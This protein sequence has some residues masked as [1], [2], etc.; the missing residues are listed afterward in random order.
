M[1]QLKYSVLILLT[2]IST[3]VMLAL[4]A[5]SQPV[6]TKKLH[7]SRDG[8]IWHIVGGIGGRAGGE[9]IEEV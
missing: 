3:V 4:Y 5:S 1:I 8:H 6:P 7:V 9:Y 2:L